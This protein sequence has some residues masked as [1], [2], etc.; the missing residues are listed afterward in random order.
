MSIQGFDVYGEVQKYDFNAL[1]NIPEGLVTENNVFVAKYGETG[2]AE[3]GEAITGG[4]AVVLLYNSYVYTLTGTESDVQTGITYKFSSVIGD[5]VYEIRVSGSTWNGP[6]GITLAKNHSPAFTGWPTSTTPDPGVY[7]NKIATTD[8]VKRA[9]EDVHP[10]YVYNMT[11]EVV[12]NSDPNFIHLVDTGGDFMSP[13]VILTRAIEISEG[14]KQSVYLRLIIEDFG[15]ILLHLAHWAKDGNDWQLV[16][17]GR[18]LDYT[19]FCGISNGELHWEIEARADEYY[20]NE[21]VEKYQGYENAGKFLAVNDDGI[22]EPV[23]VSVWQ[24][25]NY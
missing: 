25:G 9:I 10:I 5:T 18:Y 21:R 2:G 7:D 3:V 6:E 16:F 11:A 22:V 20:A 15:N 1:E 17:Q 19:I 14:K 24:G 4:K 13:G 8:F 12:D 23:D